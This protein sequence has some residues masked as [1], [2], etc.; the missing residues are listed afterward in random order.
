MILILPNYANSYYNQISITLVWVALTILG[1]IALS[2]ISTKM[3]GDLHRLVGVTD[4][5][6]DV[7][8][9][10]SAVADKPYAFYLQSGAGEYPFPGYIDSL[11]YPHSMCSDLCESM[12]RQDKILQLHLRT[13]SPYSEKCYIWLRHGQCGPMYVS[14]Q[15][16]PLG[17]EVFPQWHL[18]AGLSER[19]RR[20]G[21]DKQCQSS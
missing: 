19:C 16:D 2:G 3:P 20:S 13:G 5:R 11:H 1:I 18:P 17:R 21:E 4:Y 7:C 10:S 14:S 8:G 12:S 6:G 9:Y 15:H